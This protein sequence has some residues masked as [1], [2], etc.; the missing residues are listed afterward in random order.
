MGV[1]LRWLFTVSL[2]RQPR[3]SRFFPW[4][5]SEDV[6]LPQALVGRDGEPRFGARFRGA[7]DICDFTHAFVHV[8]DEP[9][10]IGT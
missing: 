3:R 6:R 10:E 7:E 4:S 1:K 5:A 8:A 9:A 2:D